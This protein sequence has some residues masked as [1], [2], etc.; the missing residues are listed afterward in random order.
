MAQYD[1]QC[2]EKQSGMDN[3]TVSKVLCSLKWNEILFLVF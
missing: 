2:I 3:M 1:R